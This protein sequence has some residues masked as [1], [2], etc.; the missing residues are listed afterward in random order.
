MASTLQE[1]V[2]AFYAAGNL[3]FKGDIS[4]MEAIWSAADDLTDMGPT[5]AIHRGRQAV[6]AEFA[7]ESVMG[8]RG[9]LVAVDRQIVESPEMGYVVCGQR[10]EAI[11]LDG[12]PIVLEIRATTIFRRENGHWRV[13]HNH[14]DRL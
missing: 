4:G 14:T 1:A 6:M 5:G 11:T 12:R 8:F 9:T 13:V 10:S 3:M 7:K 2:D